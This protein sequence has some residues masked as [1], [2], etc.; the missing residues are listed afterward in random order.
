MQSLLTAGLLVL[1][2]ALLLVKSE[3]GFCGSK[4]KISRTIT[5]FIPCFI[6]PSKPLCTSSI[7][8]TFIRYQGPSIKHWFCV[9][10]ALS[11]PK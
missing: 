8:L 1:P 9:S 5:R 6:G 3:A 2:M 11:L 7:I 10:A 4:K